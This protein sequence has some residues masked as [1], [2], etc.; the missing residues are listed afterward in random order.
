MIFLV[1]N[2]VSV[3]TFGTTK[4]IKLGLS[5]CGNR[6]IIGF[7]DLKLS[8]AIVAMLKNTYR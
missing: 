1:V 4:L 5:W 2:K 8:I 3:E 6:E 7:H